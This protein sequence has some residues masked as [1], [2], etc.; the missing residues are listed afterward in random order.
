MTTVDWR[1]KKLAPVFEDP[2]NFP[3]ISLWQPWAGLIW[4]A[5]MGFLGKDL[6]TRPKRIHY[7]GK[8]VVSAALRVEPEA[9]AD[10]RRRLVGGGMVPA[11]LFDRMCGKEACRKA[12]ALFEVADCRPMNHV[13][14]ERAFTD[15]GPG[16]HKVEGKFVWEG[17]EI[18]ALDPFKVTGAQ[19]Y[20]RVSRVATTSAIRHRTT[21]E[22]RAKARETMAA[23]RAA[24]KCVCGSDFPTH[25]AEFMD[26]DERCAHICRCSRK[27]AVRRMKFVVVG[28]QHNPFAEARHG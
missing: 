24:S 11:E 12:L 8:L 10:A 1:E 7:R 6:E 4:L 23:E 26:N 17:G 5:G 14:H 27:Y 13:D 19:G 28:T 21:S 3:G 15:L 18:A 9:F 20:F 22:Q 16:P 2:D 25:L